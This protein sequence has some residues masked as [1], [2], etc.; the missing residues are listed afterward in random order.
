[1]HVLGAQWKE[2]T[3]ILK[4]KHAVS[5]EVGLDHALRSLPN[6][7]DFDEATY[8]IS[9]EKFIEH[10]RMFLNLVVKVFNMVLI[11]SFALLGGCLLWSVQC[12][13]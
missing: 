8:T 1:M 2:A 7:E 12:H 3:I 13:C 6:R 10:V 5:R 9:K 11:S 4:V